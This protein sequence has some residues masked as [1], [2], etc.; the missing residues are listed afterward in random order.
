MNKKVSGGRETY[1]EII[2]IIMSERTFL[3]IPDDMGN[4]TTFNFSVRL[5]VVKGIDVSAR[6]RLFSSST[7]FIK[8]FV[9]AVKQLEEIGVKAITSNSVNIP[10]FTSSLLQIPLAYKMFIKIR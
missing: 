9:Q 4:A 3:R 2:G 5:R 1:V 6:L 10:V 8:P 7:E